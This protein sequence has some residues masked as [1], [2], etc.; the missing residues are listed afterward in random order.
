M[1]H[2][3]AFTTLLG[4]FALLSVVGVRDHLAYN[5]ALWRSVTL[6]RE[7]GVPDADIDAGYVVDGWLYFARPEHAP[8]DSD[9]NAFFPWLTA[10]GGLL[11]Y[12][13]ANQPLPGWQVRAAIPFERWLGRSG[14]IYVLERP[15]ER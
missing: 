12:Q 8:R 5:A 7:Q 1:L 11:P 14:S 2:R 6:L 15:S 4:A 3:A 13:V 10:P 9:G